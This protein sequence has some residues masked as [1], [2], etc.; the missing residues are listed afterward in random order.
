MSKEVNKYVEYFKTNMFLDAEK[1]VGEENIGRISPVTALG[2]MGEIPYAE[3]QLIF[4]KYRLIIEWDWHWHSPIK[5][6]GKTDEDYEEYIKKNV[7]KLFKECIHKYCD[8]VY[9]L[10]VAMDGYAD[11][12]S[13]CTFNDFKASRIKLFLPLIQ[14]FIT[15]ALTDTMNN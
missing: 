1:Y 7:N 8:Y 15:K 11:I 6:E 13:K 2:V 5:I 4:G 3:G 10:N 14:L 12:R 9:V